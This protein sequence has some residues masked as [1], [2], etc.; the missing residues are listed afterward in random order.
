MATHE[1]FAAGYG[2]PLER[3]LTCQIQKKIETSNWQ[4]DK[5]CINEYSLNTG[6]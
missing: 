4:V 3:P 6:V 2:R 5:P 1:V